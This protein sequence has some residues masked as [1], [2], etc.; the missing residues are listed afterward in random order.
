MAVNPEAARPSEALR[1]QVE[2]I[3]ERD[4]AST[5]IAPYSPARGWPD[6]PRIAAA[7]RRALLALIDEAA[8]PERDRL[9]EAAQRVLDFVDQAVSDDDDTLVYLDTLEP[10]FADLL[11]ILRAALA[12]GPPKPTEAPR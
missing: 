6:S 5:D 3:R 7:D 11:G 10:R 8:E 2:A 12:A 1:A 4:A 9:R